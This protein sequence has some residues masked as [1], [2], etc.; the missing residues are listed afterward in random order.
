M[1]RILTVKE[2]EEA[3]QLGH[4]NVFDLMGTGKL[5]SFKIGRSR[6][7]L[8][9]ELERFVQDRLAEAEAELFA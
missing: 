9:S 5:K 2:V 7:V 8:E 3:L 1:E 4:T 6:R